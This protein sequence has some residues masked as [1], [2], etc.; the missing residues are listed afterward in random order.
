M[1]HCVLTHDMQTAL[2]KE[3]S[4]SSSS[5]SV[6][7][8]DDDD[9]PQLSPVTDVSTPSSVYLPSSVHASTSVTSTSGIPRP[10]SNTEKSVETKSTTNDVNNTQLYCVCRTPYDQTKYVIA[11]SYIYV[12]FDCNINL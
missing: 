8:D 10:R 1:T 4:T 9:M 3:T 12:C 5:S 11:P 7:V 6:D 2:D